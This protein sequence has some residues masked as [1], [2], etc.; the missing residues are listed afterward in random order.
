M[1]RQMV[2]TS[3]TLTSIN[4]SLKNDNKSNKISQNEEADPEWSMIQDQHE[5]FVNF[6]IPWDISIDYRYSYSR[7][8]LEKL[9]DKPLTYEEI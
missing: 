2:P 3:Q 6:N 9:S 4:W 1:E 7:P 5:D 8:A